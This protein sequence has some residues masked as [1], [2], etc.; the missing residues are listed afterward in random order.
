[1]SHSENKVNDG[2]DMIVIMRDRDGNA[3]SYKE[4]MI[5]PVN[6]EFYAVLS[7]DEPESEDDAFIARIEKDEQGED[8][9]VTDLTEDELAMVQKAYD[10]LADDLENAD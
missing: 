10:E 6:G 4:E 8:V 3:Y 2:D 7:D 9:Y 5:L 1:M